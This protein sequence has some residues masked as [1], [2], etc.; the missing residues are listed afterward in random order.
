MRGWRTFLHRTLHPVFFRSE[1]TNK[2]LTEQRLPTFTCQRSKFVGHHHVAHHCRLSSC[3]ASVVLHQAVVLTLA[4]S[5]SG[6]V[7]VVYTQLG[8][9]VRVVCGLCTRCWG[10]VFGL[11]VGCAHAVG[12]VCLG[13]VWV[14]H[15]LLVL[16]VRVVCGLC[17]RCW[18]CVF[19]LCVGCAHTVG[20]VCLGCV[21][22]VHMLLVLCVQVVC[23]LCTHCWCCVFGLC[24]GCAHAVGVVCSGCVWVVHT[25]L[26]LCVQ[27]VCGLC[28]R[29]WCCVFGLCVGCA[30][31][32]GVVCSGCALTAGPA[33]LALQQIPS[34]HHKFAIVFLWSTVWPCDQVL[35]SPRRQFT[36][37]CFGLFD[38]AF[39][40]DPCVAQSTQRSDASKDRHK[41]N[42]EATSSHVKILLHR[43]QPVLTC[44]VTGSAPHQ[45]HLVP[46]E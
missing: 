21:W 38:T 40:S 35:G 45:T 44:R 3:A 18:G 24:V 17:T 41:N 28:T 26:E 22:V 42:V 14:V 7:W 39:L 31:T 27:V 20:V 15:I 34:L 36:Q 23:G 29:C 2:A 9:C 5:P 19:G 25:L 33:L 4:G 32:V 30:H 8:L 37:V 12:V 6:C 11:C 13:C 46:S 10:C 43:A 1:T 16:C